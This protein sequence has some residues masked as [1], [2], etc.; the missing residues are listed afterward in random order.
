MTDSTTEFE[1]RTPWRGEVVERLMDAI[2][3]VVMELPNTALSCDTSTGVISGFTQG[4]DCLCT[5]RDGRRIYCPP[6]F[7]ESI[8][9][10]DQEA[11]RG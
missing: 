10:P 6:H 8:T 3:D 5:V 11:N 7:L 4:T 2:A 9:G 1:W